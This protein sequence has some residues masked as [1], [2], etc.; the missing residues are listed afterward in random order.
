V[1]FLPNTTLSGLSPAIRLPGWDINDDARIV[2]KTTTDPDGTLSH[3]LWLTWTLRRPVLKGALKVFVPP[4]MILLV[5]VTSFALSV[6][7][8]GSLQLD[9]VNGA[10]LSSVLFHVSLDAGFPSTDYLTRADQFMLVLY[11]FIIAAQLSAVIKLQLDGV[12]DGTLTRTVHK[13]T[14]STIAAVAPVAFLLLFTSPWIVAIVAVTVPIVYQILRRLVA[15]MRRRRLQKRM[16][17]GFEMEMADADA[18]EPAGR[19]GGGGAGSGG[20]SKFDASAP[21]SREMLNGADSLGGLSALDGRAV[22]P[23]RAGAR[24]GAA[25]GGRRETEIDSSDGSSD[26][27]EENFGRDDDFSID[28]S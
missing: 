8:G 24:G 23:D 12:G 16:L 5:V 11:F 17:R 19:G 22:R 4:G 13:A 21:P 7:S 3:E 1:I 26:W 20:S 25:G 10:L 9:I 18:D 27:F 28:S 15:S 2:S 14:L 6:T